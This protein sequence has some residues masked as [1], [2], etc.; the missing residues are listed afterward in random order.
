[1]NIKKNIIICVVVMALIGGAVYLIF[2]KQ[3]TENQFG[4]S[5]CKVKEITFY[6]L[7]GCE[8]CNKVKAED[9]L[10]KIENLGIEIKK[11]N[12]AVG[13]VRH[14]F[15]GVPVFIINGKVY[16][17]YRTFDEI[18]ALLDCPKETSPAN[19][20][21]SALNAPLSLEPS[22]SEPLVK[23]S[24]SFS[25]ERGK[26]VVFESKEIV[27]DAS[28]FND[29]QA[30]FYNV[31]M[32]VSGSLSQT[33]RIYFFVVKDKNG[34]IRAAANA[35][36]V[37]FRE[38]KGFHQEENEMVCNNCGNRYPLEKI[39]TEKGG[40]NPGPINPNLKPRNGKITISQADLEQVAELF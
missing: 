15:Q 29:S 13:P 35:C 7:D 2:T 32:P 37:C 8:W 4:S 19:N 25:G 38:R 24:D 34:I 6:Y 9:T 31:E 33:K 18:K 12:A 23:Y 21:T 30:R 11:I 16:E 10:D 20:A 36:Q 5:V 1:M 40:C 3:G 39:A 22:L 27:L 28:I 14:K 17:G 26:N